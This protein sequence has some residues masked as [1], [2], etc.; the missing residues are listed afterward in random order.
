M[1][2]LARLL[3]A[4]FVIL[5]TSAILILRLKCFIKKVLSNLR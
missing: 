2:R 3:V 4:F 5:F 1:F